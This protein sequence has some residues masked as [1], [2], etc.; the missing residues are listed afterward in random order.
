M[1]NFALIGAAG[2]VA[3]RHLKAI[4]D[5]HNNLIVALDNF[6]VMGRIDNY[7]P[8]SEFF[9]NL[10]EFEK[11]VKQQGTPIDFFSICTPNYLHRHHIELALN[12]NSDVICEKPLVLYPKDIFAL[13]KLENKT[14]RKIYNILQ[15]RHHSI[16]S[17]LHEKIKNETSSEVYDIDLTYITSRG[18][19]YDKSW[20]GDIKKSGGIATNIGIHFFDMLMWIFGDVKENIVHLYQSDKA[21]GFLRLEK[22][23]VRWF[24]SLDYKDVPKNQEGKRTYR[25]IV[26]DG[27]EI[28][29]SEGFTNLHTQAYQNILY[30]KGFGLQDVK[31]CIILTHNIRNLTPIGIKSDYH[32]FLKNNYYK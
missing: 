4:K 6:D 30:D 18:K 16:I 24:L 21:A 23:N 1:K 15:L 12:N 26:I 28:E 27:E 17:N 32:P 3:E 2:F 25:S 5:T 13:E 9:T 10:G 14:G 7:F 29:F 20:K 11:F 19:W 31:P 8:D 22:A